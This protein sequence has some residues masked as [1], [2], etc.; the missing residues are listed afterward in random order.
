MTAIGELDR[1]I[2]IR[3]L[4]EVGRDPLNTPIYEIADFATLWANRTDVSDTERYAA[5]TVGNVLLSRFV[6][7]S[8]EA[9]RTIV[10]TD[11]I[12]HDGLEWNINGIKEA[13]AGRDRF[14]EI[15]AQA[16]G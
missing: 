15:T 12:A 4:M 6:V 3:R 9:S 2:T 1:R 14:L 10:H 16:E 7:R 5:G 8:S 13:R 11:T